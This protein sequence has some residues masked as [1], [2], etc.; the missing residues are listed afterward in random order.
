LPLPGALKLVLQLEVLSDR[1]MLEL[2]EPDNSDTF[3]SSTH[4]DVEL[5]KGR[6]TSDAQPHV[7]EKERRASLFQMKIDLVSYKER[8]KSGR[9]RTRSPERAGRQ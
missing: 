8:P 5:P 6:L 2:H 3:V 1:A 4:Q 7:S 9:A